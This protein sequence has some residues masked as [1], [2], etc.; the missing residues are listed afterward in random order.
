[1]VFG[2]LFFNNYSNTELEI[3]TSSRKSGLYV[4]DLSFII[5]WSNTLNLTKII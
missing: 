2:I 3:K 1:M 4:E 5:E